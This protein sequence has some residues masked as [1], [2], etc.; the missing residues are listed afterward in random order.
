MSNEARDV[1]TLKAWQRLEQ[2]EN[3]GDQMA[4]WKADIYHDLW[5][6]AVADYKA[7]LKTKIQGLEPD[8]LYG[9]NMSYHQALN[10]VL[11]II[12]EL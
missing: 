6:D 12:E 7:R 10:D 2:S 1:A 3:D 4:R 11:K 9:V 5:N 8:E